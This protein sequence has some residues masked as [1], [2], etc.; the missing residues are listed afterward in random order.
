M[1]SGL[2]ASIGDLLRQAQQKLRL[3]S[4]GSARLD[5]ELLMA[6]VLEKPREYLY[7]H[8]EHQPNKTHAASFL[9]LVDRRA[10]GEPLAYLVG[11]KEF[12]GRPF[13]VDP[14]VLVPRP[15]TECIVEKAMDWI[16]G[17]SQSQFRE[18]IRMMDWGTGS[19]CIG[20]TLALEVP[21]LE[22]LLIDISDE[23][24]AVAETNRD[25]WRIN[26]QV[27]LLSK[28]V[29]L[30][31]NEDLPTSW[32]GRVDLILANPPYLS[33]NDSMVEASVRKFE[34]HLALYSE[35][36]GLQH[37]RQWILKS[38]ELLERPGLFLFEMGH[39]QALEVQKFLSLGN[40]FDRVTVGQDYSGRDRWI[41][42]ELHE[43]SKFE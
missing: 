10:S 32:K 21:I 12:F 23:A 27:E 2:V 31:T 18:K 30:L 17:S 8:P 40:N 20:L 35:E 6:H 25:Q 15:E 14:R 39:D 7:S 41:M 4:I 43:T 19:G 38:Q 11:Q 24:L 42:C 26:S 28:D 16:K 3:N 9:Q 34:P 1:E 37:I 22:A 33:R 13:L 29:S 5:S 36:Q